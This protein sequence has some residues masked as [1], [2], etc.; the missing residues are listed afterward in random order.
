MAGIPPPGTSDESLRGA[1]LERFL[2]PDVHWTTGIEEHL[3]RPAEVIA[4]L[5]GDPVPGPPAYHEVDGDGRLMRWIDKM[6][7][8]LAREMDVPRGGMCK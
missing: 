7:D 2:A 8:G 6:A 3:H 4:R 1:R 5:Q